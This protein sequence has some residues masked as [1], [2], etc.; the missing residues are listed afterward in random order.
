MDSVKYIL[1]RFIGSSILISLLFIVLNIAGFLLFSYTIFVSEYSE[2]LDTSDSREIKSN[3]IMI[4]DNLILK[5]GK[6]IL[7]DSSKEVLHKN[8]IWAMLIDNNGDRVW[9]F[10]LPKE[11]PS[12]YTL[13]D[14]AKFSRF[15]LKDYP[16]YVWEHPNGILVTG[17]PKDKYTKFNLTYTIKEIEQFP[18]LIIGMFL[19]NA[20]VTFLIALFIGLKMVKSI[21]PIITGIKLMSKGEPVL[22]QEKGILSDISKSINTVS[23]ELQMKDEKLRKK[24]EARSNWIA[25]I[26]H[27]IRTP[28]SMIIGYAGELEE[29]SSL[30]NREQ[31]QVS[32]I[33]N[34]GVKIRE[35]VNDLNLVSKLEYNMQALNCDKIR[36]SAFL[37]ELISEFINNNLDNDFY[38]ELDIL[39]EDIIID[40]DKKLLKRAISNL[41]QNSITHNQQGCIIRVTSKSDLD[42]CYIIV[43]DDGKGMSQEKINSL[44]KSQNGLSEAYAKGQNHGLGILIVAGIINAHRGKLDIMSIDSQGLK[45]ILK[46]P[47]IK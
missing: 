15:F 30:S 27:D 23:K 16:V 34:Q 45:T 18:M 33:C 3:L 36:V 5:D 41:I 47:L 38:V 22:L 28:L 43:E 8:K 21:K 42:F 14:V 20:I 37:R 13:T 25:G 2:N 31:E 24:E 46:L 39:N 9:G 19:V 26:S 4:E 12:H 10:D 40:A 1:R 17:Y 35:L 7:D 44:L 6:F 11:I 32:I 29:S